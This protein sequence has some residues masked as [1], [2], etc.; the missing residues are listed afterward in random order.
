MPSHMKYTSGQDSLISANDNRKMFDTIAGYYDGTNRILSLGLDGLWRRK[1]VERL[2]TKPGGFYLDVGCGTGDISL[3]ILRQ[4]P[5]SRVRGIDPSAGMLELGRRKVESGGLAHAITLEEGNVLELAYDD[6]S[7][8]GAIASFCIR[9]V[10]D[11]RRG[12]SEIQRV[13]RPGGVLVI[14]ELTEPVGPIMKPLFRIYS[15]VVMPAVTG[16]MSSVSAYRYLADS[17]AHFPPP[18]VFL[19]LM[20]QSGFVSMEY[21]HLTGG[22]VTVFSGKVPGN[23]GGEQV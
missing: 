16:L 19:D 5:A 3:E 6:N 13:V 1:G 18:Q 15:R 20:S 22:I 11:R 2:S 7:F 23:S 4:C 12:L 10:T 21:V 17:M 14:V 9:N 8:D